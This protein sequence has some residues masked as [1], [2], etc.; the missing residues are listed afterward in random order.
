M[1]KI[2]MYN[3]NKFELPSAFHKIYMN[4]QSCIMLTFIST[5]IVQLFSQ[6][7]PKFQNCSFDRIRQKLEVRVMFVYLHNR[8]WPVQARV[9]A[10]ELTKLPQWH[11]YFIQNIVKIMQ[12]WMRLNFMPLN[13]CY[14]YFRNICNVVIRVVNS[15]RNWWYEIEG[16]RT[17]KWLSCYRKIHIL[18]E[19]NPEPYH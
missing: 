17:I 16:E 9:A 13:I 3:H 4:V 14:K 8:W 15:R 18:E 5:N 7:T 1:Q 19:K 10:T 11:R 12:K 6:T 2:I